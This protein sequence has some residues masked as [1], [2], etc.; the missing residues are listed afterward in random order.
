MINVLMI[1]PLRL[2]VDGM[3]LVISRYLDIT[4]V[5]HTPRLSFCT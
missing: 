2:V 4:R 3:F 1:V 5:F